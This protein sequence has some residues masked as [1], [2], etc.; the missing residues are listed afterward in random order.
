MAHD[1]RNPERVVP[2]KPR[3]RFQ[4]TSLGHDAASSY[5]AAMRG[6]QNVPDARGALERAK[7]E[8][9]E[10]YRVKPVDGIL[11]EDMAGGRTCLAELQE[12]LEACGL[13]LRDARGTLDRLRAADLI[14]PLEVTTPT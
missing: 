7:Q 11:L 4:V 1:W 9:A 6:A 14:Q 5:N 8:W 10:R 13:T 12:T 3:Q 2:W